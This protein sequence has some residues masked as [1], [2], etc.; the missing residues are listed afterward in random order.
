MT[1]HTPEPAVSAADADKAAP[2]AISRRGLIAA[3]G[4]GS[5]ALGAGPLWAQAAGAAPVRMRWRWDSSVVSMEQNTRPETRVSPGLAPMNLITPS[6]GHSYSKVDLSL[7]RS[8][9]R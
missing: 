1:T 6:Q 3:A 9:I 7:S 2:L 5:L 4:A 8:A